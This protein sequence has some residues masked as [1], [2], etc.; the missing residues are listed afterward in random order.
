VLLRG[1]FVWMRNEERS[2]KSHEEEWQMKDV[3]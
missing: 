3:K 1:S 2:T